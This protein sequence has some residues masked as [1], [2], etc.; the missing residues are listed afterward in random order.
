MGNG[1]QIRNQRIFLH[2]KSPVNIVFDDFWT[3]DNFRNLKLI[4]IE[5]FVFYD[6]EKTISH[7]QN[8]LAAYIKAET[9]QII[10]LMLILFE[11]MLIFEP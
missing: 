4:Q 1:V 8:L 7:G 11:E 3:Y 10:G 6:Y 9:P 2:S 5:L